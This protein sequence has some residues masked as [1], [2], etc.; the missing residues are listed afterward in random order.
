MSSSAISV[1]TWISINQSAFSIG[2]YKLSYEHSPSMPVL[3]SVDL[4]EIALFR[5][6]AATGFVVSPRR[7]GA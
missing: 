2:F 7:Q 4:I 6:L 3:V 1:A 5:N